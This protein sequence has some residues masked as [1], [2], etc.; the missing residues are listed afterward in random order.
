MTDTNP[1]ST[2]TTP[3]PTPQPTPTQYVVTGY[4]GKGEGLLVIVAA[5]NDEE[6]RQ[7]FI[8]VYPEHRLYHHRWTETYEGK[9][10]EH[11]EWLMIHKNDWNDEVLDGQV[12]EDS[13][14]GALYD[15][16]GPRYAHSIRMAPVVVGAELNEAVQW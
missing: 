16:D 15:M 9:P 11:D 1:A 2:E 8:A 7:A 4:T 6:A 5:T 13:E 14:L 10:E 3:A 12:H